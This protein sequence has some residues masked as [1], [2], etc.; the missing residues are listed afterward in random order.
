M[1]K[2]PNLYLNSSDNP[3]ADVEPHF[4]DNKVD[5]LYVTDRERILNSKHA[6]KYGHRRSASAAFG[7]C[8]V[9][10]GEDISWSDLVS[11]SL[12]PSR[13]SSLPLSCNVTEQGRFPDTPLPLI[14]DQGTITVEPSIKALQYKIAENFRN[15]I[16][17]RLALT[18][19][20]EAFVYIHGYRSPFE[21]SPFVIAQLWHYLGRQGIPIAYSWPAG[22]P[23]LF[24]GYQYDRESGEFTVYHLKQFIKLLSSCP[25]LEKIHII[26]HSRG[27]DVISSALRELFIEGKAAAVD[28]KKQ[29]KIGTLVLAAPDMDL[30]VV[31]QRI[32][33][34]R[35]FYGLERAVIYV[36]KNDRAI[37]ASEMLFSSQRRLGQLRVDDLS[38]KDRMLLRVIDQCEIINADVNVGITGHYYFYSS[39]AVSSD[40]ILVL[41]D[42]LLPGINHGRPLKPLT[43]NYW[44]VSDDYPK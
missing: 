24:R 36:S 13:S 40:L 25:E 19:R 41:R 29:F 20:K 1:M 23:G 2:T 17:R 28:V 7:S 15:E 8:V 6:I 21:D 18:S 31:V 37:G 10:F 5:V 12:S 35:F 32:A 43:T 26:A 27:T 14:V 39:P 38:E 9:E 33:A 11:Q 22:S 34:E 4:R 16:H 44:Q 30:E 3:F 42:N